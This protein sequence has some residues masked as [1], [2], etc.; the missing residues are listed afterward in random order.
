MK[1][2]PLLTALLAFAVLPPVAMAYQATVED[3]SGQP[4]C[5]VKTDRNCGMFYGPG[6][7][8]V[9][10]KLDEGESPEL[11][12]NVHII[13]EHKGQFYQYKSIHSGVWEAISIKG[14]MTSPELKASLGR[15]PWE[16]PKSRE[17]SRQFPLHEFYAVGTKVYVGIRANDTAGF[18][19]GSIKEA[20]EIK[21][22]VPNP[23]DKKALTTR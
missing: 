7:L 12:N 6:G 23:F 10:I 17:L 22:L 9:T 15:P 16:D 19:D 20:F 21:T 3:W 1:K 4:F 8:G 13:I 2:I 18:L 11:L 14:L 5:P